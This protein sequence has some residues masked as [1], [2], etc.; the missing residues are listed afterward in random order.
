MKRSLENLDIDYYFYEVNGLKV[1]LLPNIKTKKYL[2]RYLIN[3][4]SVNESFIKGN[5]KIDIPYGTAH[6]LEHKVFENSEIDPFSFYAQSGAEVNAYTSYTKT[7]YTVDG[8]KEFDK[9]LDYL[10]NFVNNPNFTIEN[11]EKEKGIIIEEIKMHQKNPDDIL[12]DVIARS[13]YKNSLRKEDIGGSIKSVNS[14][15]K[16]MLDNCYNEFYVPNN[17][18]LIILGNFDTD[19][20]LQI[21]KENKVLNSKKVK[22]VN[23]INSKEPYE[24][25]VK[26]KEVEIDKLVLNK[27]CLSF[28]YKKGNLKSEEL[29]KF[30][31]STNL[32]MKLLIGESSVFKNEMLDKNLLTSIN[33]DYVSFDDY[34]VL[35]IYCKTD[36]PQEVKDKIIDLIKNYKVEEKD[37]K[38]IMNST[39]AI[40]FKALD[41]I[42]FVASITVNSINMY[43]SLLDNRLVLFR[44][45]TT[46][47]IE[48]ARSSIDLDN[49]SFIIAKKKS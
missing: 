33:Y 46:K 17:S 16:E 6:F 40:N 11:V 22:K 24:V 9:N 34:L 38:R 1:Y 49:Y 13:I 10:I 36:N 37:L 31:N 47:D 44:S 5:K 20:A 21:I 23:F 35:N 8:D 41:S 12:Y 7:V 26:E 14:I 42:D 43:D 27:M 28:K 39:F 32:L 4:G 18:A 29:Y 15:T 19:R 48:K 2:M 45:I 25:V 3:Y 30:L